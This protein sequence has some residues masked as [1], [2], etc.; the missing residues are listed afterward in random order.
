MKVLLLLL[1]RADHIRYQLLVAAG[2]GGGRVG[3][4]SMLAVC[5]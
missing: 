1:R 3:G 2:V 5:C 4:G